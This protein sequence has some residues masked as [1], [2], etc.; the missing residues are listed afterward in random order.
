VAY[1]TGDAV[2]EIKKIKALPD[3]HLD[4]TTLPEFARCMVT[5]GKA[6]SGEKDKDGKSVMVDVK[7]ER[8][9]LGAMISML[10]VAV[11]QLTER[12]EKLEK[13]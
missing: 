10:T 3:G 11:Q 2:T 8:R 9:D 6:D 7:T 1:Y 4:F 13:P 12:V 5:T